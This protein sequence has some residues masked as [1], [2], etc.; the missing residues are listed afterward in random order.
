MAARDTGRCVFQ[1]DAACRCRWSGGVV[2]IGELGGFPTVWFAKDGEH[3]AAATIPSLVGGA[4]SDVVAY[5][6][7]WVVAG[8]NLFPVQWKR[9]WPSGRVGMVSPGRRKRAMQVPPRCRGDG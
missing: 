1:R 9:T 6:G 8:S 7:G 3:W 4:L 2:A 5:P